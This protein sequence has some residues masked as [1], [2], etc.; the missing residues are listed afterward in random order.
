MSAIELPQKWDHEAD[1]I[2]V[3]GGTAGLPASIIVAEAGQKATVLESRPQCGGS[4]GMVVGA[5]AIAGSD[6]Q[7]AA[8]IEDSP[9]IFYEDLVNIAGADP[10]IA[11]A[12]VDNQIDAYNMFKE[13]G[14]KWPGIVP[15]PGHSRVRG[16]GWLLGYG[17]KLV[18]TLENRAGARGVEIL[19]RHRAT[20]LITHHETGRII[21]LKVGVKGEVKNFKAKRAV[22][23]ASGGFGR[24]LELI[25]EYAPHMVNCIPKMPVGH[26][27]DGLKMALDVGAATK[28][29]GAAVAGSWPVCIETHSRAIWALDWGGIMVNVDGKRFYMESSAEGFYGRMTE[30]GIRQPGGAYWV[31]FDE[32][33]MGNIGRIEGTSERNM[34]HVKDLER[35]KRYKADTIEELAK[36]AGIDAKGMRETI[37]KYN[38]DIDSVGYDTVFG[39]KFQMG[40]ARPIVKLTPPF[41][42]VK[43]VTSTT[44]LKGGLK[45]DADCHVVNNYNEVIPGL[46][47]AGEVAGGFWS[48]S[49]LLA[50]MTSGAVT[51]GIIAG[52]NAVK[53]PAW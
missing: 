3:G 47:A 12:F 4:F 33:I 1:V 48:K 40:L 27:G 28:D 6:E 5:F 39:R 38:G 2:I 19:F 15:L 36:S 7:K 42:A 45:I 44:S 22:I 41:Y 26:Q 21:G 31:I 20:R 18:K 13:E 30:A 37:D 34:E 14:F 49:Y 50:V 25:A 35:C 16:L 51:Q 29:I 10:K 9:D 46:Y 32:N 24:N 8:G 53:E 23:L 43:C 11:R 52:R 17:P